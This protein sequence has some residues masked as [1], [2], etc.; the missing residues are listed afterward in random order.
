[1]KCLLFS[2][3]PCQ[4]PAFAVAAPFFSFFSHPQDHSDTSHNKPISN[5]SGWCSGHALSQPFNFLPAILFRCKF[6]ENGYDPALEG[7]M[8]F[9]VRKGYYLSLWDFAVWFTDLAIWGET[10][11]CVKSRWLRDR[12]FDEGR[13][14]VGH[15][16]WSRLWR[17]WVIAQWHFFFF[18]GVGDLLIFV[19]AALLSESGLADG[20]RCMWL[21]DERSMASSDRPRSFASWTD[22]SALWRCAFLLHLRHQFF[23]LHH[24]RIIIAGLRLRTAAGQRGTHWYNWRQCGQSA[25]APQGHTLPQNQRFCCHCYYYSWEKHVSRAKKLHRLDYQ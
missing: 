25:R 3:Q 12:L 22:L 10:V 5:L 2:L 20:N 1:M 24:R 6:V 9:T 8:A 11:Q 14:N 21:A 13:R 19:A 23:M 18:F 15:V 17:S 4:K 16:R 7:V